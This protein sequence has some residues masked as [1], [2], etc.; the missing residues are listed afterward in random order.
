MALPAIAA[1]FKT[2]GRRAGRD[3]RKGAKQQA[4]AAAP[5]RGHERPYV[6]SPE[7]FFV[8]LYATLM[9]IVIAIV[10]IFDIVLLGIAVG[11]VV[12]II[13]FLTIGLWLWLRAGKIPIKKLAF[14]LLDFIPVAKFF[15]FWLVS[16]W[17]SLDKGPAPD[18]EEMPE[19]P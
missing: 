15:P 4:I 1:R 3:I 13:A 7:G 10:G 11:I 18:Q 19:Q 17:T 9:E 12:N 6:L 8:L 14:P 2:A 16:V 5:G